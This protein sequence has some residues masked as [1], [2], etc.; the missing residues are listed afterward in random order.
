VPFRLAQFPAYRMSRY[1][2]TKQ[3]ILIILEV[4]MA[5]PVSSTAATASSIADIYL[6]ME[7]ENEI[8]QANTIAKIATMG[9]KAAKD[10][11]G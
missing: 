10:I 7:Q 9:L 3:Q 5:A 4:I 1:A 6:A 11:V 8:N 2:L